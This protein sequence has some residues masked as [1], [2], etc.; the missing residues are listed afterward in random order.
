MK[1]P[2]RLMLC[3]CVSGP[4]DAHAL[5]RHLNRQTHQVWE[6]SQV[7][8]LVRGCLECKYLRPYPARPDAPFADA[9]PRYII[10][11]A[12]VKALKEKTR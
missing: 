9:S 10:T 3:A 7:T 12:G 8:E 2:V 11:D 6:P 4:R 1:Q 5:R